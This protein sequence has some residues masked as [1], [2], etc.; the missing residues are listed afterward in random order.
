MSDL[1]RRMPRIGDLIVY[2]NPDTGEARRFGLVHRIEKDKHGHESVFI[3]WADGEGEE[4]SWRDDRGYPSSNIHNMRREFDVI[5]GG[6]K[7][8]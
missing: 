4:H 3:E 6:V 8:P 7:I 1:N 5:R 2:K